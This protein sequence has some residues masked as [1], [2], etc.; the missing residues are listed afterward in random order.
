MALPSPPSSA[1][2]L[3]VVLLLFITM[4]ACCSRNVAAFS[5]RNQH[6][7]RA[8]ARTTS[9]LS[10]CAASS[11][12][13]YTTT[14]PTHEHDI[15]QH[16]NKIDRS[17][18]PLKDFVAF[19]T[20][21]LQEPPPDILSL[22]PGRRVVCIG[23]VHGD[24]SALVEFLTIAGVLNP[25]EMSWIG[26]D[27]I[28]VQLGDILDRGHQELACFELL[29]RLSQQA[30]TQ[31][32]AVQLLYGN[33]EALNA[34]GLFQYTVGDDEL[35]ENLG[36]PLDLIAA[37]PNWRLQFAGNSPVR[38]AAFEPGGLLSETLCKNFKVAV[39]IGRTLCVHAGLTSQHLQK[40]GGISGMNRQA[41]D[42][43]LTQHH[44]RN[45]NDGIYASAED[46]RKEAQARA[47]A[48]SASMPECLGGG[49]G[50]H[51]PVWMRDYSQPNDSPPRNPKAQQMMDSVLRQVN[52]HR[53]VMGHTPQ[54]KIN[55]ALQG[56]AWRID[57]G[58]SEGVMGG[59]PEVLEIIHGSETDQVNILTKSG[60]VPANERQTVDSS[61]LF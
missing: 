38:W 49:I 59:T 10:I 39:V 16:P 6:V 9:S 18:A 14:T 52:C 21:E 57:V 2:R 41:R 15:H 43:I 13:L 36:K 3:V 51:S 4:A 12:R 53:M 8:V 24:Y 29:A 58:A 46:I 30:V 48:A 47:N 34:V 42:W 28:C 44:V 33:H 5:L 17:T 27:T 56:Q 61:I 40:Y 11:T 26:G 19:P 55:A 54:F 45:N 35:E 20:Y 50:S 22:E 37:S 60:K 31:G 23:D 32:G 1:R 7:T 25:K